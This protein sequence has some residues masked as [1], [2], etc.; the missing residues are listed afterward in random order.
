MVKPLMTAGSPAQSLLLIT[1]LSF[2]RW[3]NGPGL[4][5]LRSFP[6]PPTSRREWPWLCADV[7]AWRGI[8]HLMLTDLPLNLQFFLP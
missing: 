3:A 5:I 4:L 6:M 1:A 2:H 7:L 8:A